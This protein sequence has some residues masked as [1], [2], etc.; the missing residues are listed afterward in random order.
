MASTWSSDIL[1]LLYK[2]MTTADGKILVWLIWSFPLF[3]WNYIF[4]TLLT[5]NGN[6]RVLIYVSLFALLLNL[7]LNFYFIRPEDPLN[8]VNAARN[9]FFTQV[10]VAILNRLFVHKNLEVSFFWKDILRLISFAVL[11][12]GSAKVINEFFISWSFIP[13]CLIVVTVAFMLILILGLLPLWRIRQLVKKL[14]KDN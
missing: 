5:A 7:G 3:C 9:V 1:H 13:K 4:G 12:T 2:D 6:V 14:R 11:L 10:L 8:A